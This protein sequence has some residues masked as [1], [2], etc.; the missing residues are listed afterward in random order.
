M[1]VPEVAHRQGGI[2]TAPQAL[3]E[4]WSERQVRRRREDGLWVRV[5]GDALALPAAG[6]TPFQYAVAAW[7]T[8]PECV[9]SHLTAGALHGFPLAPGPPVHVITN[10]GRD[11]ARGLQV[12]VVP[13][14]PD[15]VMTLPV[16][17]RVTTPE[18]TGLDNLALLDLDE[19][20]DLWA[21]LST[22]RVL[23]RD[24][25]LDA[26]RERRGR[27]GTPRLIAL[28]RLT[29]TGAVSV[30][31]LKLH[32]LLRSAGIEGWEAGVAVSDAAGTIGVV[33]VLFRGR[34]LVIEVDGWRAHSSRAAFVADRRRQ[35]RLEVAGYTV[36]RF[37][38]DDLTQ[39]PGEVLAQI[40][41]A[42]AGVI[43]SQ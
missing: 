33:D 19:A 7:L 21:W 37:T 8:W 32:R 35:N 11:S 27:H 18:R 29:R 34:C 40:R 3:A 2:F 1:D 9:V 26:V 28:A 24:A 10:R 13:V 41:S 5:V 25:L 17:L 42:L 30:G 36:L 43:P 14:P 12:H 22:R 38:V 20:L 23:D 16:G 6:W 31:E 4:G 15:D 39:R